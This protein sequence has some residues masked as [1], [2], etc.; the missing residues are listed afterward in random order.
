[1]ATGQLVVAV[2]HTIFRSTACARRPRVHAIFVRAARHAMGG[3]FTVDPEVSMTVIA[4]LDGGPAT[5]LARMMG[6]L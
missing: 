6:R 1:M 4:L 2:V 5:L 3:I